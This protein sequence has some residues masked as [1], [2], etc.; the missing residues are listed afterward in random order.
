MS[1][2]FI[3]VE[4]EVAEI[5]PVM[6]EIMTEEEEITDRG[7]MIETEENTLL[8][9]PNLEAKTIPEGHIQCQ[10]I[11]E[12]DVIADNQGSEVNLYLLPEDPELHQGLLVE[13]MT[14]AL[15]VGS[16]VILQKNALR[17]LF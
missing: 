17:T 15:V 14:N 8:L 10:I 11:I 3:E 4:A 7:L 16:L 12:T 9:D 2:T 13:I 5:F 1:L 6:I